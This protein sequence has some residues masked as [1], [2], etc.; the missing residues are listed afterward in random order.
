M[1][2]SA[3]RLWFRFSL[4]TLFVAVTLVAVCLAYPLN[5]IYQRHKLLNDNAAL[6]SSMGVADDLWNFRYP[7]RLQPAKAPAILALFGERPVESLTLQ[8][9]VDAPPKGVPAEVERAKRLFPET[10]ITWSFV[11]RHG[12]FFP[13][14]E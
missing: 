14:E 7:G 13:A 11:D 12:K 6:I 8:F 5:W 10:E 1:S 9:V 4:R 2:E 3:K